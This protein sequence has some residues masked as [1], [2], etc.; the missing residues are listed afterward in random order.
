MMESL[1]NQLPDPLVYADRLLSWFTRLGTES[2]DST[3]ADLCVTAV[4]QLS[5]CELC[6]LYWLSLIHI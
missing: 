3:L 2:D 4:A 5:Q 6:Q 1:F